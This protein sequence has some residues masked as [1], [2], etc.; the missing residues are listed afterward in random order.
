MGRGGEG[1]G[2]SW[3]T[4]IVCLTHSF[5][6]TQ[7]YPCPSLPIFQPFGLVPCHVKQWPTLQVFYHVEGLSFLFG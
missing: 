6:V 3:V 7:G 4:L 1:K 5:A 2:K